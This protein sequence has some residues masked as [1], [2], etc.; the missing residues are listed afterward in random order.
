MRNR[1]GV[2][3]NKNALSKV[4]LKRNLFGDHE[5]DQSSLILAQKLIDSPQ[6]CSFI[7]DPAIQSIK[8]TDFKYK[9]QSLEREVKGTLY[10][11]F[12]QSRA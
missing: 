6:P 12:L 10:L 4:T 5:E 8:C 7:N 1:R 9:A 11:M 3:D 2:H